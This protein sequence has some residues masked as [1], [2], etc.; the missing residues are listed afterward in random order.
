MAR[1]SGL[2]AAATMAVGF[3]A[4][5]PAAQDRPPQELPTFRSRADL[6]QLD[7]LVLDEHGEPIRG[8]TAADF[9][10]LRDGVP[11]PLATFASIDLPVWSP[12][13]AAWSREIGS[14]VATNRADARRAVVLVLDDFTTRWDPSALRTVRRIGQAA[15]DQLGPGDMG[16]VVYTLNRRLG[17]EFTA[18]RVRLRAAVDRFIPSGI[19]PADESHF[20]ASIPTRGLVTPSAGRGLPS[21]ACMRN[22]I[23]QALRNTADILRDWPARK[24]LVLVSPGRPL[25]G[26]DHP[27]FDDVSDDLRA[28]I[29]ALQ[30]ANVSIYEVDPHGLEVRGRVDDFGVFADNVTGGRSI[31]DTNNPE[32]L[33][34]QVF[35]ENSSYYLLGFQPA[36]E[37]RDGRFHRVSVRVSREGAKVRARPGYYA[38]SERARPTKRAASEVDRAL[39]GGLPG[40]DVPLSLAV[41]PFGMAG[42]PGAALAVVAGVGGVDLLGGVVELVAV[43]FDETWKEVARTAGRFML[44]A[45]E[46]QSWD[47]GARLNVRPGR[48][49]VRVAVT[50]ASERR[51]G[52]VYSSVTVPDFRG[53]RLS[54]S[55][56]VLSRVTGGAALPD[57]L[58][59]LVPANPTTERSFS[60]ADSVALVVR[61]Y[62]GGRKPMEPVRLSTT[63]VDG[64]DRKVFVTDST[65]EFAAFIDRHAD[66]RVQLPL[67]RLSAG[68]YLVQ[69]EAAEEGAS[70]RRAI[71]FTVRE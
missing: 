55:G 37:K 24:I 35:H 62:Q 46:Q 63:I 22:C 54:L 14:D 8:L 33:V 66:Y 10:V 47:V 41:M 53:D 32:E 60:S 9:T 3:G 25:I 43:A 61:L 1:I 44:P 36:D 11:Q 42:K 28:T 23:L 67:E 64:S 29:S 20:T 13:S 4:H 19:T 38:P 26:G 15:I 58:A 50:N 16:A 65:I 7:V 56:I 71:R 59:A 6:V 70:V 39:S 18:D 51:T 40:T 57:D 5:L 12:G 21:G 27:D 68:E 69:V 31:K 45:R 2:V 34:P 30:Q 49:Q 48:Y 52:S 17:Q